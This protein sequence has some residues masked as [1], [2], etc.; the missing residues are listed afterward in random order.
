MTAGAGDATSVRRVYTTTEPDYDR[1][2]GTWGRIRPVLSDLAICAG[3]LAYGLPPTTQPDGPDSLGAG[4]AWDTVL[5]PVL[6]LPILLR[7]RAPFPAA[8]ALAAACVVSAIPTF[9]QFRVAVAIP[10]AMLI[11]FALA[12]R[13]PRSPAVAGLALVLGG[14]VFV[15]FTDIAVKIE[16]GP[17]AA[18]LFSF[19]LCGGIWAAG[20]IAWST[21]QIADRLT[22]RSGELARQRE[23]TAS[24][25]VE[26][27][28][29]RLAS[30]LD[31]AARLRLRDMIDL[32]ARGE[33][34]LESDPDGAH[35]LFAAIE[36][37]GRD[38]LNEMR[39][40]LG[41]L[42]SDD[43]GRRSPRPTLG[44]LDALLA[45]ARA[46]GRLVDLEVDGERRPLPAGVELAAYRAVQH[47]LVTVSGTDATP[48]TVALRYLPD[49]LELEV[50]GVPNEGSA[51][52]AALVAARERVTT[53]GG[54]FSAEMASA[55]RRVLR[56][57][58]P[59]VA[60]GA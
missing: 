50:R 53:H 56:A 3:L 36:R 22:E 27:E 26:L 43:R 47:A 45:E 15:A 9:S 6:V 37:L 46:G 21:D 5:L 34:S 29:A 40:L 17:A 4:T 48:A 44:Q 25:A 24:L 7:R 32:A 8:C 41:V 23:Q 59:V 31:A 10:A 1:P 58:L 11:L 19:P 14:M 60:F 51:A 13:V 33:R 52:A 35:A 28:R 16:G 38:S 57:H 49:A 2:V 42:R 30:D 55:G 20:R 12:S 54:S 18:V 39:G